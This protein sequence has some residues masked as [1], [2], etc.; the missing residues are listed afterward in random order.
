ML[1]YA[2]FLKLE[3]NDSKDAC[4]RAIHGWL[5]EKLQQK[6]PIS[7]LSKPGEWKSSAA[8]STAWLRSYATADEG[9]EMYAW[10]LKHADE[11][12]SGRQWLVEVGL[13]VEDGTVG[14]SCSI[15]TDELS[16][17]ITEPVSASRPR[18]IKY[19]LQN[20]RGSKDA[21][22]ANNT[23]GVSTKVVGADIDSYRALL[24]EIQR[25]ERDYPIILISS[26]RSKSYLV[27]PEI[28]QENLIG[29]AQVVKTHPDFNS[30]EMESIISRRYSVW[31]GSI[32]IVKP[33]NRRGDFPPNYFVSSI[34]EEW[35]ES[36]SARMS[37]LLG[38]V[39][40]ITNVPKQRIRIRPEGVARL[41]LVRRLAHQKQKIESRGSSEKDVVE[42][43]SSLDELNNQCRELQEKSDNLELKIMQLEDEKDSL[44]NDLR[45]ERYHTQQLRQ[46]AQS[47]RIRGIRIDPHFFLDLASRPGEPTPRECL[48]A[49]AQ[50]YPDRIVVLSSALDSA[51]DYSQFVEGRRLLHMLKRLATEFFDGMMEGGD[52]RARHCFTNSEYAATES[53]STKSNKE[54]R[55]KRTFTYEGKSIQ[56]WRHLKIG[57][58]DDRRRSIRVHFEWIA[59]EKKIVIGHCGEHLPVISH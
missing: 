50:A 20:L 40:H 51:S 29:L 59:E 25:E 45:T 26:G 4:L 35:G 53:E 13:K 42:L 30:W 47:N 9:S 39:T 6:I 23:P 27:N 48:D 17:L 34:V 21:R 43:L 19:L 8:T 2:N 15:N 58:A 57:V 36:Q 52:E 37:H 28:L 32:N 7:E 46:Q 12:V 18:L 44:E 10:R 14:L 5:T 16:V 1:V 54:M 38:L 31:D 24:A 22:F 49:I 41:D 11:S 56:M 33:K 55:K 3:G